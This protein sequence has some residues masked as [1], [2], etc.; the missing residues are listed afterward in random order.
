M[1]SHPG[2][3][4]QA[5]THFFPLGHSLTFHPVWKVHQ[6]PKELWTSACG[7]ILGLHVQPHFRS[8]GRDLAGRLFLLTGEVFLLQG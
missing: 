2:T 6:N 3:V 4:P 5:Q 1:V 8:W 7:V